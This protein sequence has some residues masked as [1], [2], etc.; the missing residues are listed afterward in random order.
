MCLIGLLLPLKHRSK[1][2]KHRSKSSSHHRRSERSRS[3][4]S[5]RRHEKEDE[6][7]AFSHFPEDALARLYL[8]LEQGLIE[9]QDRVWRDH[10]RR[11]MPH[12]E[13][14]RGVQEEEAIWRQSYKDEAPPYQETVDPPFQPGAADSLERRKGSDS[15]EA[16]CGCCCCCCSRADCMA[17]TASYPT[18]PELDDS[19]VKTIKTGPMAALYA[20]C[21]AGSTKQHLWPTSG[22]WSP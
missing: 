6:L 19:R 8:N 15:V 7:K 3:E 14:P 18:V 11:G 21:G 5:Q 2:R 22:P 20:E 4:H 9:D 17:A 1:S 12:R 10:E 13:N 16:A